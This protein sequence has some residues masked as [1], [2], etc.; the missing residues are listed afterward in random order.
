MVAAAR[1]DLAG[2]L[3]WRPAAGSALRRRFSRRNPGNRYTTEEPRARIA[4][5]ST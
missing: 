2:C 3:P 1:P 5:K 4:D